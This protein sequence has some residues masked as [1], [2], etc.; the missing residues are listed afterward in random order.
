MMYYVSAIVRELCVG[1]CFSRYWFFYDR[2]VMC[3]VKFA[4]TSTFLEKSTDCDENKY[5][6]W[7]IKILTNFYRYL[8]RI[9]FINASDFSFNIK[10]SWINYQTT[11]FL[12]FSSIWY[13]CRL[14]KLKRRRLLVPVL[15]CTGKQ[16]PKQT[17]HQIHQPGRQIRQ[18]GRRIRRLWDRQTLRL[19]DRQTHRLWARPTLRQWDRQ[20]HRL[21]RQTH[22][23]LE[24]PERRLQ[25]CLVVR[26]VVL[27]PPT[28]LADVDH[29]RVDSLTR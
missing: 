11:F 20:T 4:L 7:I 28:G 27:D 12:C 3:D 2:D 10:N 1:R 22:R 15:W 14:L 19:L 29:Q 26:V 16:W 21:C 23:L 9:T 8:F 25:D 18:P 17:G 24:Q 5:K 6:T 13:R